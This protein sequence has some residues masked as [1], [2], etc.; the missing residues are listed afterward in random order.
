MQENVLDVPVVAWAVSIKA[1]RA[2]AWAFALGVMRS[3]CQGPLGALLLARFCSGR[4]ATEFCT[5]RATHGSHADFALRGF[6]AIYD[7]RLDIVCSQGMRKH[8]MIMRVHQQCLHK[9][10]AKMCG[11]PHSRGLALNH[12]VSLALRFSEGMVVQEPPE[13]NCHSTP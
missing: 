4:C 11:R 7:I 3:A 9:N 13:S 2:D 8:I 6:E 1:G 5:S 12:N 10:D